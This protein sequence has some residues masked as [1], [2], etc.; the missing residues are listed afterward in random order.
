MYYLNSNE[1]QK[2]VERAKSGDRKALETVCRILES[3]VKIILRHKISDF[4]LVNDLS[5]EIFLRLIRNIQDIKE[6]V[7]LRNFVAKMALFVINDYFRSNSKW[8]EILV[9][10]HGH[11]TLPKSSPVEKV[12]DESNELFNKL[13]V[14]EA[15]NEIP[16]SKNKRLFELKL[17]GKNYKDISHELS[18]SIGSAKMRFKR[19]LEFLKAKLS[20]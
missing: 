16:E 13:A 11:F 9:R 14:E 3:E 1:L 19:T 10:E 17:Q 4:E 2:L 7:K 8:K 5:Q 18:I 20:G 12:I 15:I 6:P